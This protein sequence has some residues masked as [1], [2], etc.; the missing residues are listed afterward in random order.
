MLAFHSQYVHAPKVQVGFFNTKMT[1]LIVLGVIV[2]LLHPPFS[3][4]T[5]LATYQTQRKIQDIAE[6][7]SYRV[8]LFSS[9]SIFLQNHLALLELSILNC[10]RSI[11]SICCLSSTICSLL[12]RLLIFLLKRSVASSRSFSK[13]FSSHPIQSRI[14]RLA[15]LIEHTSSMMATTISIP[16]HN[17]K[18]SHAIFMQY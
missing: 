15:T 6:T 13:T 16:A 5:N 14:R 2:P 11:F 17:S 8:L 4:S 12:H 1:T 10:L 9:P 3:Y 7:L 18:E